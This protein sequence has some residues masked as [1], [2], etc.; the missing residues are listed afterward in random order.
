MFSVV[1]CTYKNDQPHLLADALSSIH[2]QDLLP[3]EV[4]LVQDGPI[5]AEASVIISKFKIDLESKNIS[6]KLHV[7]PENVGHGKAR[8]AGIDAASHDVI[9]ICDADDV[10]LQHRFRIQYEY[11][12]Q[13]SKICAVGSHIQEYTN[14]K[15][16]ARKVVP[17]NSEDLRRYCRFRCPINQ[18]T[19]MFRRKDIMAVGGYQDYY[20]NEDY[21]LWIR[22]L[23]AGYQLANIPEVLVSAN[24]DPQTYVRRGGF[25]YFRSELGIQ[26]LLLRYGMSNVAIFVVNVVIRIFIQLLIPSGLRQVVFKKFFRNL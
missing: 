26:I 19:V 8:R 13:N 17:S 25:R 15:P 7:F 1:I 22:L 4:I 20:H 23:N 16:F 9:A 18:M 2:N 6:F 11:L 10:N 5:T 24:V 3:S 12:Y 21:F 14:G